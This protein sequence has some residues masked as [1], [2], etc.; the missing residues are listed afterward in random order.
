MP[1]SWRA[2][3]DAPCSISQQPAAR[4]RG[5]EGVS[6]ARAETHDFFRRSSGNVFTH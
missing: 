5:V 4:L 3:I 1:I 2:A 6:T